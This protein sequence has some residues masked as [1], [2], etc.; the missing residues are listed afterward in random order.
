MC[1]LTT[2]SMLEAKQLLGAAGSRVQL[3]GVDANPTATSVP[4]VMAYSR[5]HSMVNQWDFLTGSL[6]QL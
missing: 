4:D 2:V 1:P 3:L 6:A 5:A